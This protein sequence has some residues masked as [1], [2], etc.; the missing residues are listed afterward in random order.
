MWEFFIMTYDVITSYGH[1]NEQALATMKAID[2]LA[3]T[4][5]NHIVI[6]FKQFGE[7]TP[8]NVLAIASYLN[9]YRKQHPEYKFSLIPK[10][11]DNFLSHLGFYQMIGADFG[12]RIGE[13]RS[14][15][16]CVPIRE[17]VFDYNFYNDI[18]CRAKELA[19]LLG[20]DKNLEEFISYI[21]IETIR[22]VYEHAQVEKAFVCAQKWP[23]KNL[24]EIAI[25]DMGVG[26]AK[27]LGT[28]YA[29]KSEK[30]LMYLS[31]NPGI[32]ARSNYSYL[33]KNDPWRNS[34][35]GLYMLKR[36]AVL[37]GGSFLLCSKKIALQ[38]SQDGIK[39]FETVFPGTAIAI[40]FRT[41]TENNF[42]TLRDQIIWEG[43]SEAQ[44]GDSTIKKASRSSGGHYNG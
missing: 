42:N 17:I 20:F 22:N 13:A 39:E 21:L 27:A 43:E 4:N 29:G 37:Y 35:Y 33:E 26:I 28:R 38:Q 24:V 31:L 5:D 23:T 19:K 18:E 15:A 2:S 3:S 44:F 11:S 6:N 10:E 32:S 1:G 30:E 14:T 9:Y 34:G 40:H 36:L 7:N 8:F 16:N 12:K 25:V 41:D